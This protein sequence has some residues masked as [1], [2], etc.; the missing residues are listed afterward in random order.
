MAEETKA[1][2]SATHSVWLLIDI[3]SQMSKKFN[4]IICPQHMKITLS[5]IL[6]LI[7]AQIEWYRMAKNSLQEQAAFNSNDFNDLGVDQHVD[8]QEFEENKNAMNNIPELVENI[9]LGTSNYHQ[10]STLLVSSLT[11]SLIIFNVLMLH[12]KIV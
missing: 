12:F 2:V 7:L 6:S 4:P 5:D 3:F 9:S 10:P 1:M 8:L 11:R